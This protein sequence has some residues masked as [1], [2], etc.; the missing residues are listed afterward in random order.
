MLIVCPNC[1]TRYELDDKNIDE[2]CFSA[3]CAKCKQVFS[4]YKPVRVEEIRFHD[5]E[6]ARKRYDNENIITISN[7][8]GGVAKTSTCLNLGLSLS[9]H[10]G[11]FDHFARVPGNRFILRFAK[12]W[13]QEHGKFGNRN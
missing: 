10:S 9:L 7:Q 2:Q 13:R 4:A 5:L 1:Q 6:A 3:R 12:R 11:Q 8:K